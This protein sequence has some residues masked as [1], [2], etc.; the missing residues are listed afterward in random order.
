[1]SETHPN[2]MAADVV[3]SLPEDP[4]LD[5]LAEPRTLP[6]APYHGRRTAVCIGPAG[7]WIELVERE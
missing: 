1:M 3:V 7:E 2:L 4:A 6:Q 5:W